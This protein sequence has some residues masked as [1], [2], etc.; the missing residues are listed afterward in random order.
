[1]CP[2]LLRGLIQLLLSLVLA[3]LDSYCILMRAGVDR[4]GG[5]QGSDPL[6]ELAFCDD[7][8]YVSTSVQPE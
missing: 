4:G 1:V 7:L 5:E 3:L 6:H 8:V 2:S